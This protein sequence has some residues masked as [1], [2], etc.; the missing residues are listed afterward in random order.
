[1][2]LVFMESFD[3][4]GGTASHMLKWASTPSLQSSAPVARTGT[5]YM[6]GFGGG[7][8]NIS[9]AT[10]TLIVG[11]AFYWTGVNAGSVSLGEVVGGGSLQCT[12]VLDTDGKVR[13]RNGTSSGT[14]LGTSASVVIVSGAWN[15]IE[16]KVLVANS[17]TYEVKV[18]GVSILSGSGDTMNQSTAAIASMSITADANAANGIDD[19]Y[20]LDS[21]G[22]Y[23]NDFIGDCKV[24]LL[25]P[26]TGN[27]TNTGLTTSTGSDHGALVDESPAND[28]T[29]YN[30]G[31]TPGVKDTYN[32]TDPATTGTVYAVQASLRARKTDSATKTLAV[33][34]REN[35]TDSDGATQAVATSY[36]QY[37]QIWEKRPSDNAA[38]TVSDLTGAQFGMKVVA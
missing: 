37:H 4:Y 26:Q 13:V 19:L 31:S 8:V 9:P 20:V 7:R 17:G 12:L 32:M 3:G 38:W 25:T 14:V 29:D 5:Y 10:A 33:V 36:A 34:A 22:S 2:A 15:F 21:N 1:M 23:L 11:F 35:S 16:W 6:R 30:Y 28:D 18:N 27:G 24:E